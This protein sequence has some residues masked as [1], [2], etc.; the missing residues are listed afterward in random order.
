MG[1]Y[2]ILQMM[3]LF[4]LVGV[5]PDFIRAAGP[6]ELSGR[7]LRSASELDYPPFALVRQDGTADGFSVELLRSVLGVVGLEAEIPVAPWHQ[8][9]QQLIDGQLD[10]LPLV[11]YSTDRDQVMD[12]TAPYLRM[13]GG[14]FV[15]KGQSAIHSKADLKTKAVIVMRGDTAHE[16]ALK[17]NLADQLILTESFEEAMM[18]L[19]NGTHDAVLIQHLVGLQ[20]IKNLGIR[21]VVSVN[22]QHESSLKPSGAPVIGFGQKFC[23][24]V[25]E[26]DAELLAR[27]NEGLAIVIADGTYD[28]L[29][30]KW[31]GPILPPAP[32]SMKTLLGYMASILVPLLL[33]LLMVGLWYTKRQ[34]DEK[35]THLREEIR[36]RKK[37]QEDREKLIA[38]LRKALEEV[39][40]LGGLLPICASCKKI[41]D[42]KG[43][44]NQIE[45]YIRD[46][47]DA[48]FSHSICPD[49]AEALYPDLEIK[50]G[51]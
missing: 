6:P 3:L 50:R 40:T 22:I 25:K 26:G 17:E 45:S 49:C 42:D 41:R 13:R 29:Y 19:S 20:L 15:R 7:I 2:L 10:L 30:S 43:Y 23:F 32:I 14:I 8:I 21:N 51:R 38:E 16:Y 44:W 46:R 28:R 5:T 36:Q 24:A 4:A 34:V 1:K 27:L 9:K 35:T 47:S 11:S 48:E 39:K 33:I 12:F 18:M 37:A 31:F